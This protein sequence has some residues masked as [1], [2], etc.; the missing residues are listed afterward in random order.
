MTALRDISLSIMKMRDTQLWDQGK[1]ISPGSAIH[2]QFSEFPRYPYMA[3]ISVLTFQTH[4]KIPQ[5]WEHNNRSCFPHVISWLLHRDLFCTS[6]ENTVKN[7]QTNES[8]LVWLWNKGG[9]NAPSR[10]NAWFLNIGYLGLSQILPI[11]LMAAATVSVTTI[12]AAVRL[13]NQ[14]LGRLLKWQRCLLLNL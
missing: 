9:A 7:K 4:R 14:I 11:S 2:Q 6:T 10:R 8:V 5:S 12:W 3:E 13:E 1:V